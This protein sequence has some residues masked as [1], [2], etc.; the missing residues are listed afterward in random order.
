MSLNTQRDGRLFAALRIA[1]WTAAASVMLAPLVAMR[2]T[3]E[4][5]WTG[6]DF[7]FAALVLGAACGA[8]ELGAR[9]SKGPA[10][11][12]G[13]VLAVGAGF[14]IVWGNAAVGF[15]GEGPT[16]A[17]LTFLGVVALAIAAGALARLRAARMARAML[18]VCA[19][20]FALGVIWRD[21]DPRPVLLLSTGLAGLWLA[22]AGL[23]ALAARKTAPPAA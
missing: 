22:S 13:L 1:M 9:V 21:A 5:N 4:V 14:L 19:A 17:N 20:Q 6:S 10:Y 16:L 7:V 2:F 12:G 23:F 18:A 15:V 3:D 11:L 8:V